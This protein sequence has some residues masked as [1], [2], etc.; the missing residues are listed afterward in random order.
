MSETV[1]TVR[2][3]HDAFHPA[4]RGTVLVGVGFEGPERD[5]VV[6]RTV[7]ATEAL[8]AGVRERHDPEQGPVTWWASDRIQVWSSRPY[9]HEGKQKPLVHHAQTSTRVKFRDFDELARWVEGAARHAGVR[10]DGIDWALTEQ[11]RQ[12]A[13]ATSRVA[14]VEQ[15]RA[16][17]EAYAGALGLTR[18]T[19]V[20]IADPGMLGDPGNA[21]LVSP[22]AYSRAMAAPS[23]GPSLVLNPED[24]AVST[25][26]DARFLASA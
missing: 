26:V 16:K 9:H 2:G 14:A 8:L 1:I 13:E 6:Q 10:I 23:D 15:A 11:T 5:P 3:S 7:A 20:A 21:P 25:T 19:C 12:R 17:A 4:E 24:I 18:L 22:A